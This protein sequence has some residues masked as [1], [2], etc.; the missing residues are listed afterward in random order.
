MFNNQTIC[1]QISEQSCVGAA[2]RHASSLAQKFDFTEIEIEKIAIIITELGTNLIKHAIQTKPRELLFS[3]HNN[4]EQKY[5]EVIS[6]DH[7]PGISNINYALQDGNSTTGTSGIGLGAINRL[8]DLVDIYT[9]PAIG[10][11]IMVQLYTKKNKTNYDL[12]S[13]G[14]ICLPKPGELICGDNYDIFQSKSR[15]LAMI[16][17]GLGHGPLAAEASRLARDIFRS[18]LHLTPHLII[19]QI[20]TALRGTRGAA[21]AVTQIDYETQQI[22]FAGLGNI[23]STIYIN[24]K[25]HHMVNQNGTA[26]VNSY[27]IKDFI[28]PWDKDACLVM[29]SD[30]LMSRFNLENY[31]G[32]LTRHPQIIASVL[33]K[34]FYRNNDDLTILI[35][36]K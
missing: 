15:C 25:M 10:T 5:V 9:V 7:G 4:R 1:F 24:K 6:I 33:Y 29:H 21:V 31:P 16:A 36:K 26:G 17:D 8:S 28:Y 35:L 32:L 30:G 3:L 18:N 27:S 22:K 34:D 2:R 12:L 20:N 19:S 23:S 14:S 11:I 13:A